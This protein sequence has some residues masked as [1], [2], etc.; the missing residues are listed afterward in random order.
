MPRTDVE[1]RVHKL[2]DTDEWIGLTFWF[3]TAGGSL[4]FGFNK[5]ELTIC[6]TK[7]ESLARLT[8]LQTAVEK[9]IATF[10]EP[11]PKEEPT[12]AEGN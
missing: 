11:T 9:A 6:A 2:Q 1:I 12:N 7:D 3:D 5:A 8:S 10:G 4:D